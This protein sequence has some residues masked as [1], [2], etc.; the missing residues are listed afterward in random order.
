MSSLSKL[1]VAQVMHAANKALCDATGDNSHLSWQDVDV[2]TREH[3]LRGIDAVLN[4]PTM[5]AK[6]GHDFWLTDHVE[7]GWTYGP[8]KNRVTKQHP[9]IV[10]F[11]ELPEVEKAKDHLY[12]AI[13]RALLLEF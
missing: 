9:C 4:N 13:V 11:D 12:I 5:T 8:I 7:R 6:E 1:V 2:A 10:P 3:F